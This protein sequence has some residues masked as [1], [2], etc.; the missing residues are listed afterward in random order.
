MKA[1]M[2]R[3][4]TIIANIILLYSALYIIAMMDPFNCESESNYVPKSKRWKRLN[5]GKTYLSEKVLH[6]TRPITEWFSSMEEEWS[7]YYATRVPE[8]EYQEAR[9]RHYIAESMAENYEPLTREA[10][11]EEQ[12]NYV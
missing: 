9:R 11:K 10:W 4:L 3:Q 2:G 12:R 7:E 8:L 5:D 1:Y 6:Y